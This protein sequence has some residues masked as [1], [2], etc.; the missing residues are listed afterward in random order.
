MQKT[1][2][3]TITA[4]ELTAR[5]DAYWLG[6]L[7]A[8]GVPELDADEDPAAAPISQA[9]PYFDAFE[10]YQV[11]VA[12]CAHCSESFMDQCLEGDRLSDLA[13]KAMVAQGVS[14]ALQ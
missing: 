12:R 11:H 10:R 6:A 13:A 2:F 7:S 9:L 4:D 14:G 1:T 5:H 3:E 8:A